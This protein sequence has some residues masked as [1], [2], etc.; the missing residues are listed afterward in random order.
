MN[1]RRFLGLA[2]AAAF[3]PLGR[4]AF[5]SEGGKM[6][7]AKSPTCGCCTAWVEH[8]QA[9]GFEVEVQN[10]TQEALNDLKTR[11]GLAPE[12]TSC[13]TAVVGG[14]FVEGHV[15]AEDVKRMLAEAPAIRG[16]TVPGM[17]VGSPG[18][19]MGNQRDPYDV[20][21]IHADGRVRVFAEHR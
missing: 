9:A 2:L 8:M 17:P 15:P 4:A 5:A 11:I 3:V 19:E 1:R 20:L 21:A 13:H 6:V 14:Y 10:V 12:Q 16:L 18:M 7:V